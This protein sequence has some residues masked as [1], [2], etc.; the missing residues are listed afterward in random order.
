MLYILYVLSLILYLAVSFFVN[1]C[2][3]NEI[4]G[5]KHK[6]PLYYFENPN[7]YHAVSIFLFIVTILFPII[8]NEIHWSFIG[9]SIFM[10]IFSTKLAAKVC[11]YED[12]K[13]IRRMLKEE[14]DLEMREALLKTLSKTPVERVKE[15]NDR[16][17]L[18]NSFK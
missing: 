3:I 5:R 15:A 2:S 8:F 17:N 7:I 6:L 16:K 12:R 10:S 18:L 4:L 9:V 14:K 1:K 13:V 11:V